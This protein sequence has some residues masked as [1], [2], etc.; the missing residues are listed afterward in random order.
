MVPRPKFAPS[1]PGA[2]ATAA[3]ATTAVATTLWAMPMA[4]LGLLVATDAVGTQPRESHLETRAR[5]DNQGQHTQQSLHDALLPCL[6]V[7]LSLV[8]HKR[9]V[10][11]RE[12]RGWEGENIRGGDGNDQPH[13]APKVFHIT[14][15]VR[16][17]RRCSLN[18]PD[19]TTYKQRDRLER[20]PGQRLPVSRNPTSVDSLTTTTEIKV[21]ASRPLIGRWF[22]DGVSR[23]RLPSGGA[24]RQERGQRQVA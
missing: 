14:P 10:S 1:A 21:D 2:T 11:K 12:D 7:F 3:A 13:G 15:I 9:R 19:K 24:A 23:A 22:L 4:Y 16:L 20:P 5:N 17:H 6:R 8:G 18:G